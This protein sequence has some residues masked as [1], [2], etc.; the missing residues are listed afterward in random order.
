MKKSI[1]IILFFASVCFFFMHCDQSTMESVDD[2][3]RE[4]TELE[5]QVAGASDKFGL[6]LFSAV[7]ETQ[8][9]SNIFISPLSVSMALGMTLNG[10]DGTTFDAIQSTLELNGFSRQEINETYQSLIQLLTQIDPKVIFQIANSIW[11]RDTWTFEQE[12]INTNKKYFSAHVQG[13]NFNDPGTPSVINSWVSNNTNGKIEEI[14]QSI[15]PTTVMFLINAIYF[16]GSWQYEFDVNETINDIF[17]SP[18]G[19]EIPCKMMVQENDFQYFENSSFQAIDLPY[20]DGKFSMTIFLPKN[21][22]SIDSL[23]SQFT[24][25]NWADWTSSF[26]EQPGELLLPKFNLEYKI[27]LNDV[28]SS[29]GMR[30][31]FTPGQ[32]DFSQMYKGPFDLYISKV[33]HKTFVEVN[34]EG[35]EAAAVTSVTITFTSIGGSGFVMRIDRPFVFVIRERDSNVLLFMGKIIKPEFK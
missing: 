13:L 19:T 21:P 35:T 4:F 22:S 28:L 11:Y 2:P 1:S 6:K 7:N 24:E 18:D 20:G 32:A 23:I 26:T 5:K 17:I 31:A 30:I 15:D 14:I 3:V 8:K 27:K 12:F 33:D 34:E 16:K 10:T 25:E 29:L 9:D